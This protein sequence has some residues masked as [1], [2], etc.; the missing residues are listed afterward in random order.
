MRSQKHDDCG[1]KHLVLCIA[2]I[3]GSKLLPSH[4]AIDV[5]LCNVQAKLELSIAACTLLL[6]HPFPRAATQ[7]LYNL[8]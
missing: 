7:R 6:A 5:K 4:R 1:L 8:D 2:T 3:T